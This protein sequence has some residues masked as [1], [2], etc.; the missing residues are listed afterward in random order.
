MGS[1]FGSSIRRA[2]SVCFSSTKKDARPALFSRRKLTHRCAPAVVSTTMLSNAPHAVLMATSYFSE[3]DPRSPR[4]PRTPQLASGPPFRAAFS[5]TSSAPE[6]PL[7]LLCM[8]ALPSSTALTAARTRAVRSFS[9]ACRRA[10]SVDRAS[11]SAVARACS[12]SAPARRASQPASSVRTASSFSCALTSPLAAFVCRAWL[13]ESC[14]CT[15]SF[16][17]SRPDTARL[18]STNCSCTASSSARNADVASCSPAMTSSRAVSASV[19]S[20]TA[21]SVTAASRSTSARAA[22]ACSSLSC[23]FL[24]SRA[25]PVWSFLSVARVCLRSSC[26][27]TSR[28]SKLVSSFVARLTSVQTLSYSSL[29][30]LKVCLSSHSSLSVPES[31]SFSSASAEDTASHL[32]FD[33]SIVFDASRACA[34]NMWFCFRRTLRSASM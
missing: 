1:C 21:F 3:I 22:S 33:S 4:R 24:A 28:R 19:W 25:R 7:A 13:R 30:A 2:G 29:V 18:A 26:S 12:P 11:T 17:V 15:P 20:E 32:A 8:A 23:S 31:F 34:W 10:S 27:F 5:I 6:R 9:S 14:C 16:S